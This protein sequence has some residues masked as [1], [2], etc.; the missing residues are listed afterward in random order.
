MALDRQIPQSHLS[1]QQEICP[2]GKAL[3]HEASDRGRN[4]TD[5]RQG[6]ELLDGSERERDCR[7]TLPD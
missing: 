5:F 7:T 6:T 3:Q 1:L 4:Q 2:Q